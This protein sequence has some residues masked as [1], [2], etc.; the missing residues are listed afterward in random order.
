[1]QKVSEPFY[2][3]KI[4]VTRTCLSSGDAAIEEDDG[5][6]VDAS[7]DIVILNVHV[8]CFMK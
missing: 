6:R 7:N 8:L 5:K 3:N 1:M 4:F 2:K